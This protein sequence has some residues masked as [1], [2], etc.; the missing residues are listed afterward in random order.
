[1]V[2]TTNTKDGSKGG[3]NI[4]QLLLKTLEEEGA[5]LNFKLDEESR[6]VSIA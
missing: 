4:A 3:L 2:A 6:L 1:M 5:F